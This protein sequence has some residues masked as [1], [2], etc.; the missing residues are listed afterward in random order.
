MKVETSLYQTGM[1]L[2]GLKEIPGGSDNHLIQFAL[3]LCKIPEPLHDETA[4]CSAILNFLCYILGFARSGSAAARSWLKVGIPI[5]LKD[6]QI[7]NDIIIMKRGPEPQ[8][9]AEVLDAQG[10]VGIFAGMDGPDKFK[11]LAGNQ[12]LFCIVSY[13]V[14]SILGVRSLL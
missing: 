10:H 1:R 12:P 13:P 9:G 4:W 11:L 6:A 2:I 3:G 7:G 5:E 14:S 8:P